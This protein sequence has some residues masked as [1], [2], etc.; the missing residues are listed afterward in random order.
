MPEL[1]T[2]NEQEAS[3]FYEY[4]GLVGY[5]EQQFAA[6]FGNFTVHIDEVIADPVFA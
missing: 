3:E 4:F 5:T 1:D 2:G 6:N